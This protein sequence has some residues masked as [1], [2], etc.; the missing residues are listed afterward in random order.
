[1]QMILFFQ[2]IRTRVN[3]DLK[4]WWECR[5][6]TEI[7]HS[8]VVRKNMGDKF[9]RV[10]NLPWKTDEFRG[11]MNWSP[12]WISH[13]GKFNVANSQRW[14]IL[15]RLTTGSFVRNPFLIWGNLVFLSISFH[16]LFC[17]RTERHTTQDLLSDEIDPNC[18]SGLLRSGLYISGGQ[19]GDPG[20]MTPLKIS[21]HSSIIKRSS[22]A[23]LRFT[24]PRFG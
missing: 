14:S 15:F 7:F 16:F 2:G 6:P 1:M 20:M 17:Q 21:N 4:L 8:N 5:S 13:Q 11:Q 19:F 18:F 9:H 3:W 22:V 23:Y 12:R 10:R 24:Q